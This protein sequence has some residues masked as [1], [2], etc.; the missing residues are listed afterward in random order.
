MKEESTD[1]ALCVAKEETLRVVVFLCPYGCVG[2]FGF[3]KKHAVL[4]LT[5]KHTQRDTDLSLIDRKTKLTSM[6]FVKGGLDGKVNQVIDQAGESVKTFKQ[7]FMSL[8]SWWET[9]ELNNEGIYR[10]NVRPH[11]R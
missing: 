11:D 3:Y 2:E 4:F 8:R 10:Y 1:W 6:D 7:I 9:V 5:H